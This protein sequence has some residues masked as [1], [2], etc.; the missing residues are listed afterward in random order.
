MSCC[1]YRRDGREKEVFVEPADSERGSDFTYVTEVYID[2][3]QKKRLMIGQPK[4]LVVGTD[5]Q[6]AFL[7]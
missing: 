7:N 6:R 1:V 3:N 2:G 5:F 4:S